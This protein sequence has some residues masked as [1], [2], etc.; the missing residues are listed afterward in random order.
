MISIIVTIYNSEKFLKE[1]LDSIVSQTYKNYEVIMVNDGSTDSSRAIAFSYTSDSRFILI[2]SPHVGF[3]QAKNLGLSNVH[4]DYIIFFD[5]DDIVHPQ[6]L[7][8]LIKPILENNADISYCS[9]V[10]FND[11]ERVDLSFF[12]VDS[13]RTKDMTSQKM[14]PLFYPE[15]RNYLWNKL[16]KRELYSD[17][18]FED[19]LCMSDVQVIY[20]IFDKASTVFRVSASL[21]YYRQRPDS[22]TGK[23]SKTREFIKYR[24]RTILEE[25]TFVYDRYEISRFI[26]RRY[27]DNELSNIR[28]LF[29][30]DGCNSLY[31]EHKEKVDHILKDDYVC[32]FDVDLVI[33]YVDSKDSVWQK[34]YFDY[35]HKTDYINSPRYDS[36]GLFEYF[37]RGVDKYL[38]WVRKI[39]LIVSNIEQVPSY[40]NKEKTHIVL[41]KDI[42][43]ESILPT[44]NSSTIEMFITNIEGLSE[45]FIYANDDMYPI[46][47]MLKS[48]FFTE[49]GRPKI[50]FK[51]N[52]V[53]KNMTFFN[54]LCLNGYRHLAEVLSYPIDNETFLRPEHSIA[55]FVLSHCKECLSKMW[56]YVEQDLGP[57]RTT[58]QHTQYMYSLYERFTNGYVFGGPS[59]KYYN[60]N[61]KYEDIIKDLKFQSCQVLCLNGVADGEVDS[62]QLA[63]ITR[64]LRENLIQGV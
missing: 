54:Q 45:H 33:P 64:L 55:A 47:D 4:G 14:C 53:T 51:I 10:K 24:L 43:P 6:W 46:R 29:G 34:T 21:L 16:I 59:F 15:C 61:E 27:L 30:K 25:L 22:I 48:D 13:V 49:D 37:L 2:D 26:C 9:Y 42:M 62:D 38:P 50:V 7:E 31:N 44:F 63:E 11:G 1:A 52:Y 36:P 57:F 19:C 18:I 3:P 23:L 20:K 17:V 5:S 28:L 39:H 60:L 58:K 32:D 56:H 40:I 12:N 35:T 41:H 8:L